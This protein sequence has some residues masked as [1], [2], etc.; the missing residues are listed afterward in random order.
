[1]GIDI[2]RFLFEDSFRS[3]MAE[4]QVENDLKN[5]RRD[6]IVNNYF[7]DAT[8]FWAEAKQLYHSRAIIVDFKNYSDK[9]NST[10]FFNVS[11]YTTKKVG[12]F[13]LV[14][15]RKGLDK[16][17]INEQRSLYANGKLLIEFNDI[18][19]HEMILEKIIGNDPLDR[20]KSKEFEIIRC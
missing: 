6:L 8:S 10:T 13:A 2:F 14:F 15:S 4:A 17:A 19:L 18:E 12:D 7:K 1:L 9:L 16:S 11:K 5:H 20:L 3:Y